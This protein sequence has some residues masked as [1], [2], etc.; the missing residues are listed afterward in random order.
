MRFLAGEGAGLGGRFGGGQ[1]WGLAGAGRRGPASSGL[2]TDP[3][4]TP[5]PAGC[6]KGGD[7]PVVLWGR[8][9]SLGSGQA[10]GPALKEACRICRNVLGR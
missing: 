8:V 5:S 3:A 7:Q 9:S 2:R 6:W 10:S 4:S 1:V